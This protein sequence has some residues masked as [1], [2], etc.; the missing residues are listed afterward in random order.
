[1]RIKCNSDFEI[2]FFF[3]KDIVRIVGEIW[4]GFGIN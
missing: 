4:M 1:M 2:D 3:I